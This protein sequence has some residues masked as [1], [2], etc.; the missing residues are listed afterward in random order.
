M[1]APSENNHLEEDELKTAS[2]YATSQTLVLMPGVGEQSGEAEMIWRFFSPDNVIVNVSRDLMF[3]REASIGD[4]A[5]HYQ[6]IFNEL[7]KA[8]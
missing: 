5:K 1:G 3:P 6:K 7:R 8:A 2:D 4:R